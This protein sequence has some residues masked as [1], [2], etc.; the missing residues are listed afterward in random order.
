MT[1]DATPTAADAFR[2]LYNS[3]EAFLDRGALVKEHRFTRSALTTSG[4]LTM[5]AVYAL[6]RNIAEEMDSRPCMTMIA[7]PEGTDRAGTA[8][9][10]EF[11]FDL[12]GR[13]AK[14]ECA[15]SMPGDGH[16]AQIDVVAR[17]FPDAD[18]LL[19]QQVKDGKLLYRQ[20]VG[21]WNAERRRHPGL[22]RRFQN[23]DAAM[24]EFVRQGLDVG[25][26]E[27]SLIAK[28]DPGHGASWVLQTRDKTW[29]VP[30]ALEK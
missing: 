13:R 18:S 2:R 30:F 17:P 7:A 26:E 20:L 24:Y 19:R 21:M 12:P 9:R 27:F 1:N 16:D 11:F 3:V 23:S 28:H 25:Q 29:R 6:C 8:L 22:P 4:A 5:G 15:W 10:W 14:L